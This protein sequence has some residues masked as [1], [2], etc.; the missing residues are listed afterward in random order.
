MN[1]LFRG[2]DALRFVEKISGC[3]KKL[4]KGTDGEDFP[5]NRKP[6]RPLRVGQRLGTGL[7]KWDAKGITTFEDKVSAACH[8]REQY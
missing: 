2:G 7:A 6:M 8:L 4:G 1:N 5:V 3:P